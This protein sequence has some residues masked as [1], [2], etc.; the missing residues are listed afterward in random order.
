MIRRVLN[1]LE[2]IYYYRYFSNVK[3]GSTNILLKK[4]YKSTDIVFIEKVFQ[5]D[6][7][8]E[9]I[10]PIPI[11]IKKQK[12]VL[13]LAPHQD[14]EVIAVGG[15]LLQ[16]KEKGCKITLVFLTDGAS[17]SDSLETKII[18]SKEAKKVAKELNASIIEINIPNNTMKIGNE[19]LDH[20]ISV[21]QLKEWDMVFSIW[22][23]DNPPKH[24]IC[25][26][27]VKE[28]LKKLNQPKFPIFLYSVHTDLIPNFYVDIT[29]EEEEKLRI[30][31]FYKS[32]LKS[33][34]YGHLSKAR[35]A[36][37]S[38]FLPVSN[39]KR[40]IEVFFKVNIEEY[41]KL[42]SI[43]DNVK[44][45]ELFKGHEVCI[46]SYKCILKTIVK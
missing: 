3:N 4:I 42:V 31:G 29:L 26:F 44:I 13:V 10:V 38:R 14:D 35:D 9:I 19:H 23:I 40:Y 11:D 32:Q 43:Y 8:R 39:K 12:N 41:F 36:W 34:D 7:F 5:L 25:A 22:P 33:Q 45:N 27:F 17:L 18:R 28:A 20:L 21:F 2:S 15:T 30:I 16:L 6:F 37:S 46:N 24:R 1:K